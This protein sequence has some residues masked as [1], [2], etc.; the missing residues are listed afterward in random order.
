MIY[1]ATAKQDTRPDAPAGTPG[2]YQVGGATA[3][4]PLGPWTKMRENPILKPGAKGEWDHGSEHT[5]AIH[6]LPVVF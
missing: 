2:Y 1:H 5:Q 6:Q 3:S 4:H